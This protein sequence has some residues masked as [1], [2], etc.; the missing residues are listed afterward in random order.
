MGTPVLAT[1]TGKVVAAG[2]RRGYGRTVEISHGMG[3]TTRFGHLSE[4]TV[5]P[6]QAVARGDVVGRVGNSGRSTGPHL[7]YEIRV[8]GTP[9]NPAQFMKAGQHVFQG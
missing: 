5:R 8:R 2:W 6:G 4:I 1:A 3:V 9:R 7:H